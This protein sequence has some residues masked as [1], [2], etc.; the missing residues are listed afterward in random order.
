MEPQGTIYTEGTELL[1][2]EAQLAV[3]W[4]ISTKTLRNRRVTG[5]G[6]AFIKIGRSVRYRL[7]DVINFENDNRRLSTSQAF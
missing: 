5:G 3:R 7:R 2:S 4:S 1:F 6:V